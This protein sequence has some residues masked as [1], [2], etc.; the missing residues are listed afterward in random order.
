MRRRE[1]IA[2][3]GVAA[4]WPIVARAQDDRVWRVGVIG[5]RPEN[6]GFSGGV[7]VGY[8]AMLDHPPA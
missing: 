7:G 6:A 2:L 3:G 8:P 4:A 5:P 1:F